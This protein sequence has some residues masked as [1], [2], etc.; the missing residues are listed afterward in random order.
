MG[1]C[2]D[3]TTRL[4]G[5]RREVSEQQRQG[6]HTRWGLMSASG[7]HWVTGSQQ[8]GPKKSSGGGTDLDMFAVY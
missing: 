4:G 8:V 7:T 1:Q 3:A 6:P 5:S 2:P